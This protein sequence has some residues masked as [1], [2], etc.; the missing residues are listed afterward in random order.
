M[1]REGAGP[2]RGDGMAKNHRRKAEREEKR[3]ACTEKQP[4][5]TPR[6]AAPLKGTSPLGAGDS[7]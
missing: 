2:G 6:A 3:G 5:Q 7:A 4:G 1:G